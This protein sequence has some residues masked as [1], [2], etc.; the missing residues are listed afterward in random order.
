MITRTSGRKRR[1]RAGATLYCLLTGRPP[2]STSG[3]LHETLA[4]A[5]RGEIE[6]PGTVRDGVD[7][8]LERICLIAIHRDPDR[9]YPTAR[10]MAEAL[11]EWLAEER[12]RTARALFSAARSK[13]MRRW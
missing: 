2:I 13:P 5:I 9:R 1:L 7:P 4:K 10:A 11:D 12:A 8:E 6:P 3:G